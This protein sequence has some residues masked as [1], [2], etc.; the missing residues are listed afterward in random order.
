MNPNSA[1]GKGKKKGKGGGKAVYCLA[2]LARVLRAYLL[3]ASGPDP[4]VRPTQPLMRS[5][6]ASA[7]AKS[8]HN[9]PVKLSAK[10][11]DED[12][13]EDEGFGNYGSWNDPDPE[14]ETDDKSG[15]GHKSGEGNNAKNKG[16]QEQKQKP[17]QD[18]QPRM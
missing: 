14:S 6:E 13:D 5:V 15:E 11:Y 10:A 8:L 9:K 1:G 4:T 18:A 17:A 2:S 3:G 7:K 12:E 16:K